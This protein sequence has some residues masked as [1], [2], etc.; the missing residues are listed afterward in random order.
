M[1][2]LTKL[3]LKGFKSIKETDPPIKFGPLTMMVGANGSGKSNLLSFFALLNHLTQ[4]SLQKYVSLNGGPETFLHY[5]VRTTSQI[6][7][8]VE[9]ETDRGTN[10]YDFALAF[11]KG[12]RE[13]LIFTRESLDFRSHDRAPNPEPLYLG[14]GHPESALL[15]PKWRN[16]GTV[17]T[18]KRVLRGFRHYQ[19]HDTSRLSP[20]RRS[21]AEQKLIRPF[22]SD[23]GNLPAVLYAM[24]ETHPEDYHL[25]IE[26]IGLVA[27]FFADFEFELVQGHA[28]DDDV[29]M[30]WK[31]EGSTCPLGMHQLSDGTLRFIALATLLLL[32]DGLRPEGAI[33]IDKPELGLHPRAL[34]ALGGLLKSASEKVQVICS[35]QS[36]D[37][38]SEFEPE[39]ILV[40][41]RE[42]GS[43]VFRKVDAEKLGVWLDDEFSLGDI[44]K[45]NLIGGRP[46]R[47]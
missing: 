3:S 22:Y 2:R 26:T 32:P 25:L 29:Q 6:E 38:L 46:H 19:F 37:L 44:W 47:D 7:A 34:R 21:R 33:L 41:D 1:N 42:K 31:S 16:N 23:G 9:F 27:P 35:T 18:F 14:V 11:A 20:L 15:D 13:E 28:P 43:S 36:A 39:N 45:A 40:V 17:N 8:R 30:F 5:G 12:I 4:D 10:T 24:H